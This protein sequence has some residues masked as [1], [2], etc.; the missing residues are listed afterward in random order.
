MFKRL[1]LGCVLG[2]T[3]VT[4]SPAINAQIFP[5]PGLGMRIT[6]RV[7]MF[8]DRVFGRVDMLFDRLGISPTLP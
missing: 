1:L 4:F 7:D 6:D 5:L 3:L 2:M 8:L